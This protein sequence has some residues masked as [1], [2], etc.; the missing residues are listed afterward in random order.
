MFQI[1]ITLIMLIATLTTPFRLFTE[2]D[3]QGY[4]DDFE[5]MTLKETAYEEMFGLSPSQFK[6]LPQDV[7]EKMLKDADKKLKK[8][9]SSKSSSSRKSRTKKDP[10]L[11]S[12]NPSSEKE[13]VKSSTPIS[14]VSASAKQLNQE[15]SKT[16]LQNLKKQPEKIISPKIAQKA[17]IPWTP[18]PN[19]ISEQKKKPLNSY[20]A[21]KEKK[22]EILRKK[23]QNE[24]LTHTPKIN[25]SVLKPKKSY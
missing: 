17:T 22:L 5:P 13:E 1:N 2:L 8:E 6:A 4:E 14:N 11:D 16:Q 21:E 23:Y 19:Y 3:D 9:K 7:R 20:Q 10:N 24:N 18:K 15:D 12:E 25:K